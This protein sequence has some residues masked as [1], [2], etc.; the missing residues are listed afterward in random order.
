M[1]TRLVHELRM[2]CVSEDAAE[3]TT[4]YDPHL[5]GDTIH[6][7]TQDGDHAVIQ[8]TDPAWPVSV[9][10]SAL[11]DGHTT[12]AEADRITALAQQTPTERLPAPAEPSWEQKEKTYLALLDLA[13][14]FDIPCRP[15]G[16]LRDITVSK[17]RNGPS[18]PW[19][20]A[21]HRYGPGLLTYA[22]DGTGWSP[23]DRPV[24]LLQHAHWDNPI[25]ALTEA[26]RIAR[27]DEERGHTEIE[28]PTD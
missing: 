8:Y 14:Q 26:Q 11:D 17:H 12:A 19:K 3:E 22:W 24:H 9:A 7:V 28:H 16:A 15:A 6:L 27:V 10:Q 2:A 25:Q 21:I 23:V 20:W 18:S 5:A 4:A 1:Q 13:P